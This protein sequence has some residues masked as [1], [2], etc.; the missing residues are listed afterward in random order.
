MIIVTW[1]YN[2]IEQWFSTRGGGGDS[3]PQA[4][5]LGV[6]VLLAS[7]GG[8]F[9]IP[10][11][12]SRSYSAQDGPTPRGWSGPKCQQGGKPRSRD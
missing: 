1:L 12:C 7:S 6:V 3:P 8:R 2:M 10:G 9:P 11:H 4:A 5:M